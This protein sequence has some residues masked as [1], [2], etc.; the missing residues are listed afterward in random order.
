MT[1]PAPDDEP[2]SDMPAQLPRSPARQAFAML[3]I[4]VTTALAV[5]MTVQLR[6]KSGGNDVSR[7]CTV[8]SLLE[9]GTYVIDDCPWRSETVDLIQQPSPWERPEAGKPPVKHFYSSKP[10]ILPT[11]IAG[12]IYPF[13]AASG[14]PLDRVF[15]Q[16]RREPR[17]VAKPGVEGKVLEVP[18]APVLWPAHVFYFK[19][20]IILLNIVPTLVLLILFARFLDRYARGDWAWLFSLM[21]AAAGTFL[22][23]FEQTLNNHTVAAWSLFFALYAFLKIWD[24]RGGLGWYALAG[25]AGAFGACNELPAALFGV[26]LFA[27]LMTRSPRRTLI[28]FVPAAAVPCLV[29]LATQYAA[30]GTFHLA[31]EGFGSETYNFEGSHWLTP[32][33]YDWFNK[34]PEPRWLYLFHMTFGHHGIFSLTP[35][36][37]LSLYGAHRLAWGRPGG[38]KV[39]AWLTGVLTFAL[40]AFYTWNPKARNYGGSAQGLRWLFWLIPF[41]LLVLPAGLERGGSRPGFRRFSLALLLV[42]AFSVGYAVHSPWSHPWISD[43]LEHLGLY[44]LKR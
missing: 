1:A 24:D 11:L 6:A 18:S 42:S 40:L 10:P 22:F 17:Y 23:A 14:V 3:V 37:L 28:A 16:P 30:M 20:T 7:W 5:G 26:L 36:V 4:G 31:Y 27:L 35:I 25:A 44:A 12:L 21:S 33:E 2:T 29:F 41:W 8:W 19:P 13:R 34:H 9:R 39:V 32:L 15:Q 43:A 38:L